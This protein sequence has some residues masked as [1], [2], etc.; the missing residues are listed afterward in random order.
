MTTVRNGSILVW[1]A[2]LAAVLAGCQSGSSN[3]DVSGRAG[4]A[5]TQANVVWDAQRVDVGGHKINITCKGSGSPTIVFENGLGENLGT[6]FQT[7]ITNAFPSVRTCAYDR[8]NTGVS[9]RVSAR[10]TGEDSIRDLHTVLDVA[11]VPAPYL[12]VGHSFGGL[13]AAM[14]AGTHPAEVRGLVLID[15]SLPSQAELNDLIPER[16]RTAAMAA[17]EQNTE[18]VDFLDTLEQAKALVPNIPAIPVLVLAATSMGDLPSTWP[19]ADMLAAR[20]KALQDFTAALPRGEL[21]YVD[22]G[23]FIQTEQP[24]LVISEIQRLLENVR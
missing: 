18:N 19:A 10:H 8:V 24:K 12:L 23:H 15:P 21:R 20:K 13:L 5:S 17:D 16:E 22:S 3:P 6:W 4:A 7:G 1:C 14:Y 11:A 9:A 2:A